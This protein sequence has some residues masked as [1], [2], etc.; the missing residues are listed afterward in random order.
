MK[1]ENWYS[2]TWMPVHD[3]DKRK[4]PTQGYER[5]QATEARAMRLYHDCWRPELPIAN[6]ENTDNVVYGH[7]SLHQTGFFWRPA[8]KKYTKNM[9]NLYMQN[10]CKTYAKHMQYICEL[11]ANYMRII[12]K[13]YA[14][15]VP[16]MQENMLYMQTAC[17][18][19]A[20]NMHKICKQSVPLFWVSIERKR[21]S[22]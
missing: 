12:C 20:K 7:Q 21:P 15:Y 17:R 1:A 4:L 11:Y 6:S 13:L 19:Y 16:K 2:V 22:K 5:D 10:L 8:S 9:Q 18:N 14:K 3:P